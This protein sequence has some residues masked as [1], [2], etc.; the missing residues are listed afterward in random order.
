MV[1]SQIVPV[2]PVFGVISKIAVILTGSKYHLTEST[3]NFLLY[4]L[5]GCLCRIKKSTL[6]QISRLNEKSGSKSGIKWKVN[7]KKCET[8]P[9]IFKHRKS[10]AYEQ[11]KLAKNRL[12]LFTC[13]NPSSPH[14]D[15]HQ[16]F[17]HTRNIHTRP[18][19]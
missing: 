1:P 19:D 10:Q 14:S 11:I 4:V 18:R 12:F 7:L 2:K 9:H 17:S 6:L 8:V 16:L 13:F 5:P 3:R 15:H